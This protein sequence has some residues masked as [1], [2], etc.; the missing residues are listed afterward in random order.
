M[1]PLGAVTT[2]HSK[3]GPYRVVRYN[4]SPAVEVDGDTAPGYA[5]GQSLATMDR[6]GQ[7]VLPPGYETEWTAI[8]YQQ[9]EQGNTAG[10]VFALATL[11]VFLVLAA[12][13]ESLALPLAGGPIRPM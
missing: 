8:A 7:E 9:K 3:L 12:Q 6:L 4:L 5:S 1:V 11:F 13:Y 10:V 2:F